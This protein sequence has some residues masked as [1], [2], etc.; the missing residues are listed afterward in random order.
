MTTHVVLIDLENVQPSDLGSLAGQELR[1]CLFLGQTQTKLPLGLVESLLPLG[2]AVTFIHGKA[3]GR[4]SMDSIMAFYLGRLSVEL[5]DASF[6]L[7]SKDTGFDQLVNYVKDMG[8]Q[9]RRVADVA[10]LP[11]W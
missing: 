2:P 6:T 8:V 10:N 11:P 1:V 7:I 4:N 5:P 9:C 3:G